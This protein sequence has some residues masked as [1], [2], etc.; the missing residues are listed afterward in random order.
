M[1]KKF[2]TA[3]SQCFQAFA[4]FGGWVSK[5][6]GSGFKS[7]CPCQKIDKFWLVDFFIHCESNGILPR[8]SVH[9]ITE[10]AYHHQPVSAFVMMI[11]NCKPLVMYNALHWWSTRLRRGFFVLIKL[12]TGVLENNSKP[13]YKIYYKASLVFFKTLWSRF[14]SIR[15]AGLY[16]NVIT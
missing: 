1:S 7:L 16:R 13:W 5:T 9:L 3:E 15:K 8:I 14:Y 12:Q 10:G 11:Y 6:V 4:E 2:S